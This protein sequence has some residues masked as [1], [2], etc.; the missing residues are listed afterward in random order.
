MLLA[1]L[2]SM[3]ACSNDSD[4]ETNNPGSGSDPE[5]TILVQMRNKDHGGTVIYMESNGRGGWFYVNKANN[6]D[7]PVEFVSVGRVT[8]LGNIRNVP[9]QGWSDEVAVIPGN[10]YVI[11]DKSNLYIRLYVVDYIISTSGGIIGATVKFQRGF[12]PDNRR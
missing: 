5:G 2:L 1:I 7:G 4:D 3:P 11:R 9:E 6:F 8:G 10:G 12:I